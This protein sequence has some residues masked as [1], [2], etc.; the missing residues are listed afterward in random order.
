MEVAQQ[1]S[2]LGASDDQN[3]E[4]KEQKSK[5]VVSLRWP[6]GVEDEEQL[7]EDASEWQNTAHDDA[8]EGLGVHT[9][10][11]DLSWNLIGADGI[12]QGLKIKAR[13]N[14]THLRRFV[15]YNRPIDICFCGVYLS[16]SNE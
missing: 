13:L 12:L 6:D 2:G 11:G 14:L 15:S 4:H 16:S 8:G 5:H 7:D 3:E 10:F 9:L 1:Y